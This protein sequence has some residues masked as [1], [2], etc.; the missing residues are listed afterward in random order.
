MSGRI[1]LNSRIWI[2]SLLCLALIGTGFLSPAH[3][4]PVPE[5]K[6]SPYAENKAE[7]EVSILKHGKG[8]A[9]VELLDDK[10][11]VVKTLYAG[12]L[13]AQHNTFRFLAGRDVPAGNYSVRYRENFSLE[14]Q[15]SLKRP[16]TPD[17][18]WINPGDIHLA[19]GKLY[20]YDAGLS[21]TDP[22]KKLAGFIRLNLDGTPDTSFA[23]NG[24]APVTFK[25][26]HVS[27]MGID[28]EGN[29]YASNGYHSTEVF[30]KNGKTTKRYL[31]GWNN[32]PSGPICTGW[33][34]ANYVGDGNKIYFP[35][36]YGNMKVYDRTKAGFDGALYFKTLPAS[37][38]FGRSIVV[39]GNTIYLANQYGQIERY[40]DTG[41]DI[42]TQYATQPEEKL[43]NP[44]GFCL[45]GSLLWSCV[46]G[47]SPGPFWD[48][49][50]GGEIVLFYDDG[51]SIG[52]FE[53]FGNPG[54]AE[55][56]L[57]FMNPSAIAVD[58]TNTI[59]WITENGLTPSNAPAGSPPG[60]A[61]LRKFKIT[62]EKSAQASFTLTT[63]PSQ[64][65]ASASTRK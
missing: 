62:S 58:P 38:S 6:I 56:Q 39:H 30:D 16:G 3:A 61:R 54:L 25:G 20:V 21:E 23:D 53:R 59:A 22:V 44:G 12:R 1:S 5:I 40:T 33:I 19:N 57:E 43:P 9:L 49:G 42:K 32:D 50:G 15:S 48:S 8:K 31:A 60:N 34:N 7:M 45:N 36:G 18:K 37:I 13:N 2:L 28:P 41:K 47:P 35:T 4:D 51:D 63:P 46:T 55:D 27:A 17:G 64:K 14:Y 24:Y 11:N 29:L 26:V 65:Q 10:G 52:I